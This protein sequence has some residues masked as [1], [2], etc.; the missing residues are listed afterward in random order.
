MDLAGFVGICTTGCE[1]GALRDTGGGRGAVKDAKV[2]GCT[3]ARIGEL[4]IIMVKVLF[5]CM[6]NICRSPMAQGVFQTLVNEAGIGHLVGVDSAGTHAYHVGSPPDDRAQRTAL[7]RGIDLSG[8]RA[9][10][11]EPGDFGQFD[12]V[13][14]MDEDNLENALRVSPPEYHERIRLF[15]DFAEELE[16]REVPDP[17]Y[18]GNAGFDRVMDMV[19]SAAE[20]L[21]E[22]LKRRYRF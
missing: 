10:L 5:V 15:L 14:V 19:Q 2:T 9:R 1:T 16:D 6:G 21:L 18:G 22:D 7:A 17:Y 13:L 4:R 11:L 3:E 8:Q 12:Y 20:G